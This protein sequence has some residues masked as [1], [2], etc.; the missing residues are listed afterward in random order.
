[1]ADAVPL[2]VP[3]IAACLA[4]AIR[5]ATSFGDGITFQA[6]WAI[7]S[8]VG[9]LPPLS[10]HLIRKGVLYASVM[11]L[12]TMPIVLYQSRAVI[13]HIV[14]YILPMISVGAVFVALGAQLLLL[15]NIAFLRLFSGVFFGLFSVTQ[16]TLAMRVALKARQ[17]TP[18]APPHAD[19]A[20]Q[21]D[22]HP[23]S[24]PPGGDAM[25]AVDDR[26]VHDEHAPT[27]AV[28][29][30]TVAQEQQDVE[31]A[32]HHA[33]EHAEH[34]DL[35]PL[36]RPADGPQHCFHAWLLHWLPRLSTKVAPERMLIML[37][38][39]AMAGG[40]L[41]GMLGAG[42]PPFMAAYAIL[43]LDKDVL[44]GFSAA[45]AVFMLIRLF[46]YVFGDGSVFQWDE[47]PVYVAIWIAAAAG[48]SGG[49]Y[50]RRY[51][52]SAMLVKILYVIIF[53]SSALML[54]ATQ[55][56]RVALSYAA[57]CCVWIAAAAWLW[58]HADSAALV[59][60]FPATVGAAQPASQKERRVEVTAAPQPEVNGP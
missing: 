58:Y 49:T 18:Q 15:G 38:C 52:D 50:C 59:C 7:A 54:G 24:A 41:A 51:I 33:A 44:R 12:M 36:T 6:V 19:E 9:M 16:L 22:E 55:D 5:G 31:H 2:F 53:A 3:V 14:G 4:S 8:A 43:E 35:A 40:M 23:P 25:E 60:R 21:R 32:Q 47:W 56:A 57:F 10:P 45:P 30:V 34:A 37:C 20:E 28:A 42:G 26:P 48:A 11:Q 46:I 29:G 27:D 1:M 13:P 17:V 39:A